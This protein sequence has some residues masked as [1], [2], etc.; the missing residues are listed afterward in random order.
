M[1]ST[2]TIQTHQ[3]THV[4]VGLTVTPDDSIPVPS[5]WELPR[6]DTPVPVVWQHDWLARPIGI[7]KDFRA[8]ETSCVCTIVFP[9]DVLQERTAEDPPDLA[10]AVYRLVAANI[11]GAAVGLA[12]SD[13]HTRLLEI[14]L[15]QTGI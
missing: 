14:S 10:H 7:A 3:P 5:Q 15:H 13:T 12:I 11:A 2:L 6:D 1:D 8:D 9:G 4:A